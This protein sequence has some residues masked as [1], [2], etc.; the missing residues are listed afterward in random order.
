MLAILY[1]IWTRIPPPLITN[2]NVDS[3]ISDEEWEAFKE[4][5][6]LYDPNYDKWLKE[7]QIRQ[8][9]DDKMAL[10]DLGINGAQVIN[11]A[12]GNTKK[13][14]YIGWLWSALQLGN[15]AKQTWLK[16]KM[17]ESYGHDLFETFTNLLPFKTRLKGINL[18]KPTGKFLKDLLNKL[19]NVRGN[20]LV[21]VMQQSVHFSPTENTN[22]MDNTKME[23]DNPEDAKR[24]T[25]SY[26][27]IY[28]TFLFGGNLPLIVRS[29]IK[30]KEKNRGK[31]TQ[32]AQDHDMGVQEYARKILNDPNAT[33]LQ[34]K[35]AQFAV[36]AKKF[37]H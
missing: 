14:P 29:G 12:L 6:K 4:N 22:N 8:R 35:R 16:Y 24:F 20:Y 37:K 21:P 34:K 33:A 3:N 17:G 27:K 30:I 23:F 18:E 15:D 7:Y 25:E 28:P 36:N 19:K 31:F 26:E 11:T 9:V 5:L 1:L 13:I 10:S 2:T 32:K